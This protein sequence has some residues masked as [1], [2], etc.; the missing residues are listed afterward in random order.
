MVDDAR[1]GDAAEVPADVVA[2][3]AV[4]LGKRAHAGRREAVQ[5]QHLLIRQLPVLADV[6]QR[7][8]HEVP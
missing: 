4:G 7:R 3:R 2:L 6:P 5:L 8:D 1:T